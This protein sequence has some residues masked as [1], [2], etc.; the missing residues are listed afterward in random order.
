MFPVLE[1]ELACD[2]GSRDFIGLSRL[3][4]KRQYSFHLVL[5]RRSLL[6]SSHHAA[7][8]SRSH[9]ERPRAGVL[10][11]SSPTVSANS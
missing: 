9:M 5:L 6:E 4:Y 8:K 2:R 7:R 10:A 1:S 11:A 3:G